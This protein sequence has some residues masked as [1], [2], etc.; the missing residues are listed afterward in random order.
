MLYMKKTKG[1][2]KMAKKGEKLPTNTFPDDFSLN[3]WCRANDYGL[4]REDFEDLQVYRQQ[5]FK[6]ACAVQRAW[7]QTAEGKR[8]QSIVGRQVWEERARKA[9]EESDTTEV[10]LLEKITGHQDGMSTAEMVAGCI[11]II[12][13]E[14]AKRGTKSVE[15]LETKELI[16]IG[17][18]LMALTKAAASVKRELDWK[19]NTVVVAPQ[20]VQSSSKTGG[21]VGGLKDVID[22]RTEKTPQ[23]QSRGKR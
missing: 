15:D 10:L 8:A 7:M 14:L 17:N 2:D 5:R 23:T 6:R 1:V 4:K 20:V 11:N 3:G 22:L 12:A 18:N 9:K 16:A 13:R 19:P 21:A